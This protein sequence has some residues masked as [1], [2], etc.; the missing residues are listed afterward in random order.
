MNT[1]ETSY[2]V[3]LWFYETFCDI[4]LLSILLTILVSSCHNRLGSLIILSEIVYTSGW[5]SIELVRIW[6]VLKLI[7]NIQSCRLLEW[8]WL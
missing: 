5:K 2:Q 3:F 1:L 6:Q 4:R 8:P 7:K